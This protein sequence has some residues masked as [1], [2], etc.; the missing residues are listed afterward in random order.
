[1]RRSQSQKKNVITMFFAKGYNGI[2]VSIDFRL[3]DRLGD[4]SIYKLFKKVEF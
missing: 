3:G 2:H 1:M 4:A